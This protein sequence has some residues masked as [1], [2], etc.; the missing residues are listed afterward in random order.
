M[1]GNLSEF[2]IKGLSQATSPDGS[3]TLWGSLSNY[4]KL[5]AFALYVLV[6]TV[7]WWIVAMDT[8]GVTDE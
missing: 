4:E 3:V 8:E 2:V 6:W 1:V 5:G 7:V